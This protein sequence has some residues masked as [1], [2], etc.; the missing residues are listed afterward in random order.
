MGKNEINA[1]GRRQSGL[2]TSLQEAFKV[3]D[4]MLTPEDLAL[5][6]SQTR[7]EFVITQHFGLGQWVRNTWFYG[8]DDDTRYRLFGDTM[9]LHPDDISTDFLIKYHDH[10][11]LTDNDN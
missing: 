2:P 3:L 4:E 11:K 8:A 1:A 7:E 6:R 10:L 5:F 9:F